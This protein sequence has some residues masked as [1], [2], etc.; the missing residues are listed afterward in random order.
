MNIWSNTLLSVTQHQQYF[1]IFLSLTVVFDNQC[2]SILTSQ[3]SQKIPYIFL[4]GNTPC[5]HIVNR[6]NLYDC[7]IARRCQ[8]VSVYLRPLTGPS[9][10]H[11]NFTPSIEGRLLLHQHQIQ[12]FQWNRRQAVTPSKN[13]PSNPII[14]MYLNTICGHVKKII[15]HGFASAKVCASGCRHSPMWW[16]R[17]LGRSEWEKT[18]NKIQTLGVW[19]VFNETGLIITYRAIIF[20]SPRYVFF[21]LRFSNRE[22]KVKQTARTKNINKK[23]SF[24]SRNTSPMLSP[25]H[26]ELSALILPLLEVAPPPVW[27]TLA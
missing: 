12:E 13:A 11:C 6:C 21:R 27:L 24:R 1:P 19:K 20:S 5:I 10:P 26:S 18:T 9:P 8:Q 7:E 25:S 14:L 17:S 22:E 2:P 16:S 3:P 4:V 15:S 23:F